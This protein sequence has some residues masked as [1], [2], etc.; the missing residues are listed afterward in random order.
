MLGTARSGNRFDSPS[1][2][3]RVLYFGTSLTACFGETLA[4]FRPDTHLLSVVKDEWEAM[5]FMDVSRVPADWRH[6]RSAVNVSLP[7]DAPFL[8]VE[9]RSTREFLRTT[10]A[11][12]LSALG[13]DDLDIAAVRGPDRRVTRMISEWAYNATDDKGFAAYQGIRYLSRLDDDWECWAVF[14]DAEITVN[15]AM[16]ITLDLEPL[17]RVAA[18]YG[19]RDF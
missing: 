12:G 1:G 8:D 14:E 17:Q 3:Y 7:A 5:G 4:R 19:L 11:T 13:H 10:L 18:D 16:S 2:S 15:T 9:H 6:R